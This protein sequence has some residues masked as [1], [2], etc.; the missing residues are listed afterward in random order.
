MDRHPHR[1]LFFRNDRLGETVLNIPAVACLKKTFPKTHVTFLCHPQMAELLACVPAIDSVLPDPAPAD[2]SWWAQTKALAPVLRREKFDAAIISNASKS[3]HLA[4]WLAGIPVRVG[5]RRKW[6][7]LLNRSLPDNRAADGRHEVLHNLD[8]AALLGAD[9]SGITFPISIPED[10]ALNARRHLKQQGLIDGKPYFCMHPWSSNPVKEWPAA[11]FA[12]L[13]ERF[14]TSLGS[15]PVLIGGQ[16]SCARAETLHRQAPRTINLTGK[17]SLVELAA[18]LANAQMLV[19]NDSGPVHLAAALKSPVIALFGMADPG[20]QPQRWSP[21]GS[22]NAT[23]QK[24]LEQLSA[25]EVF[26]TA[27]K[28]FHDPAKT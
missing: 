15:A 21:W 16:E 9:V 13:S 1:L 2:K 20:S 4:S 24:P 3:A 10:A 18:L 23:I 19:S 22:K 8:L 12:A 6:G 7:G 28:I 25:D 27:Q 5:Y 11:G 17:L 14:S 26:A